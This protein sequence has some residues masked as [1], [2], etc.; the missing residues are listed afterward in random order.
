MLLVP[1]KCSEGK[2]PYW[3]KNRKERER[4]RE[5]GGKRGGGGGGRGQGGEIS[6]QFTPSHYRIT[7]NFLAKCSVRSHARW[8]EIWSPDGQYILVIHM[9]GMWKLVRY[10]LPARLSI[11]SI[12]LLNIYSYLCTSNYI[13]FLLFIL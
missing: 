6:L 13:C 4:E 10:I 9:D 11:L 8:S 12:Y 3:T 2:M 1:D 7:K 5:G